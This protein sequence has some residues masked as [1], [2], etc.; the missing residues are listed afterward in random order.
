MTNE[1]TCTLSDQE[2]IDKCEK[3]A[4]TR[5]FAYGIDLQDTFFELIKRF[6]EQQEEIK[7]LSQFDER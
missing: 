7:I 4:R 2:L 5:L 1:P 3:L 6:K